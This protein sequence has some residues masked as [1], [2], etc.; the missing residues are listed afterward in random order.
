M[1]SPGIKVLPRV[2]TGVVKRL[3]LHMIEINVQ[4]Q[5]RNVTIAVIRVILQVYMLESKGQ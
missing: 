4:P 2:V 3:I 1:V 5:V